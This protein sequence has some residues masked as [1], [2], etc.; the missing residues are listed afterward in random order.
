MLVLVPLLAFA[1]LAAH[2]TAQSFWLDE[3]FTIRFAAL[4]APDAAAAFREGARD[5]H[6]P[7][8]YLAIHMLLAPF[9]PDA[10]RETLMA[11]A[12]GLSLACAAATPGLLY[13]GTRGLLSG[14]ARLVLFALA[15]GAHVLADYALE[16]RSYA[17]GI[18]AAA[19]LTLQAAGLLRAVT[20]VRLAGFIAAG[21]LCAMIHYYGLLLAGGLTAGLLVLVPDLR[22]RL[23]IA[24]AGLLI[25]GPVA[26]YVAWHVTRMP[27]DL[28]VA[29]I[30]AS[31]EFIA[32]QFAS[33]IPRV[34]GTLGGAA[35]PVALGLGALV[36]IARAP[37]RHAAAG[38]LI[39]LAAIAFAIMA[40]L[41]IAITW[42]AAPSF[43]ARNLLIGVPLL[44]LAL[45]RA[46]EIIARTLC[47]DGKGWLMLATGVGLLVGLLPLVQLA[48][49]AKS[50]WRA[51]AATV[52][53]LPGCAGAVLPVAVP[54]SALQDPGR[55][56]AFY[57]WYLADGSTRRFLRLGREALSAGIFD[58]EWQALARAR[59]SGRDPCPLLLWS[60]H[61]WQRPDAEQV[62]A[63]LQ[64]HLAA[65]GDAQAA[66]GLTL[67]VFPRRRMNFLWQSVVLDD[68][69]LILRADQSNTSRDSTR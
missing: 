15:G 17:P 44:W 14:R 65:S 30:K 36:L 37:A 4:A 31:P 67:V 27:P 38:R 39:A 53:A 52:A 57:G 42:L 19:W 60:A 40:A 22:A 12:R 49:P 26:S 46:F 25:A 45:A 63:L 10:P 32:A 16:A 64:A 56:R 43:T 35:M 69:F 21:L 48:G 7:L 6:P 68:V 13:L 50:D 11:L 66:A 24:A 20:A 29:W 62:L 34:F 23:R 59:A 41:G 47:E 9:G 58:P 55:S 28:E 5:V 33:L 51:S 8:Y 54:A 18:L 61:D 1:V 3:L 2:L